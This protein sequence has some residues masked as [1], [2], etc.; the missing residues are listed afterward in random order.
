MLLTPDVE[1]VR[2]MAGKL[3]KAVG[4]EAEALVVPFLESK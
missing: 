1:K 4:A 2:E 3:A